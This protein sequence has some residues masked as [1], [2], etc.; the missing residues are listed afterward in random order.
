VDARPPAEEEEEEA[1]NA[2][3]PTEEKT[4]ADDLNK[5]SSAQ[6]VQ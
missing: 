5:A 1:M 3:T 4:E 6:R 2:S